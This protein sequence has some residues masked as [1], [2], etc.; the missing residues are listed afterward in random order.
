MSYNEFMEGNNAPFRRIVTA[1]LISQ[2][3]S[4]NTNLFNNSYKFAELSIEFQQ[5]LDELNDYK[6]KNRFHYS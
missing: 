4:K 3:I 2:L 1:N 6:R 5:T